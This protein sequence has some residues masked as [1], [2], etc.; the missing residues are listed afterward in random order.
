V[1]AKAETNSFIA[2]QLSFGGGAF[3]ELAP[4][5]DPSSAIDG[6]LGAESLRLAAH[7]AVSG[8]A[9]EA[10]GT[11]HFDWGALSLEGCPFRLRWGSAR[12]DACAAFQAGFLRGHGDQVSAPQSLAEPGDPLRGWL[13]AAPLLRVKWTF[14]RSWFLDA[15]GSVVIPLRRDKFVFDQPPPSDSRVYYEVPLVGAAAGIGIGYRFDD[16]T[17]DRR[18]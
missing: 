8:R 18:P 4:A 7:Y 11:A 9:S 16:R 5:D 1:G 17:G 10:A 15:D 13:S 3:V 14:F 12:I 2:P 6:S